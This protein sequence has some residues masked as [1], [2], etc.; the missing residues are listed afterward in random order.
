[1]KNLSGLRS[2]FAART[3]AL[4]VALALAFGVFAA[5]L[6]ARAAANGSAARTA[7]ARAPKNA[8]GTKPNAQETSAGVP[9]PDVPGVTHFRRLGDTIA[10]GGA[11]SPAAVAEIRKIGFV[12]DINFR[13]P[14]EPGANVKEEGAAAKAAG[15]RYYNIPFED[16]HPSDAA[17]TKFLQVITTPGN[18]PAYIHCSGGNRAAT[19]WFI[20]RM[21]VDHWSEERAWKEA[22]ALGMKNLALKK[23]GAEYA[24][25]HKAPKHGM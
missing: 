3:A 6:P 16:A 15:L 21:V 22:S 4:G 10:C 12:A 8:A 2:R 19:M 25:T 17:V 18:Q 20:K 11:T 7:N 14:S 9:A 1:M 24:R 23:F 5:P 13:L